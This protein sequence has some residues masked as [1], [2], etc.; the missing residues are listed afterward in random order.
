[1]NVPTVEWIVKRMDDKFF[2][3]Y[4]SS[5]DKQT[6]YRQPGYYEL[7]EYGFEYRSLP[8]SDETMNALREIVGFSFDLLKEINN[9]D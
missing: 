9:F 1:M 7:K 8:A 2:K 3:K 4:V 5:E 6:K